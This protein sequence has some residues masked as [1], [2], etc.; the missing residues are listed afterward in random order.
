MGYFVPNSHFVESLEQI[1]ST[2]FI[3]NAKW[4][5][6]TLP[7]PYPLPFGSSASALFHWFNLTMFQHIFH[8]YALLMDSCSMVASFRLLAEPLFHPVLAIDDQSLH[9]G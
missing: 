3:G 4:S 8:A 9:Q 7:S 5:E 2:G 1:L 6:N